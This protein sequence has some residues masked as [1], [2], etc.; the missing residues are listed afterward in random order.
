MENHAMD[1]SNAEIQDSIA[2]SLLGDPVAEQQEPQS[3]APSD[4][5]AHGDDLLSEAVADQEANPFREGAEA[6]FDVDNFIADEAARRSGQ[7]TSARREQSEQEPKEQL[8]AQEQIQPPTAAEIEQGVEQ[9]GAVVE[10]HQLND[11][12]SAGAFASEFCTALGTNIHDSGV[13]VQA[14]GGAMAKT[15]LSAVNIFAATGGD[16][17]K[18]GAIPEQSAKAFAHEVL[19]SFGTDPRSV[20]VDSQLLADTALRGAVNFLQTYQQ[21]G[22]RVTD[23]AKLN[24]PQ[25]AEMFVGNIFRAL[26]A[27]VAPTREMA[28]KIA[29]GYG[30]YLLSF[31]SK[32]GNVQQAKQAP[33]S[34]PASRKAGRARVP[35][36]AK[37]LGRTEFAPRFKT[38]NDIFPASVIDAAINRNL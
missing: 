32:L 25:A 26:G 31:V 37:N 16:L 33:Q 29:D 23:L 34:R 6:E 38:N 19:A 3:E 2:E 4:Y 18:L 12:A 20:Q 35:G 1:I 7:P 8:E 24:D 30:K 14:F 22:G 15:A 10:Q 36:G 17:G 28:L 5:H 27:P 9:L 11:A 21:H 13:D